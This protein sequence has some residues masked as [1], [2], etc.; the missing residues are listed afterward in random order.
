MTIETVK[1][2]YKNE[3][4]LA[5]VL[6]RDEL[7]QP[8]KLKVLKHSKSRDEIYD[9]LKKFKY[10]PTYQFYTGE[11]PEGYAVAMNGKC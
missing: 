7:D 2:R 5:E 10:T 4:V 9:A 1:R 11:L 3:W 8:I 6:G